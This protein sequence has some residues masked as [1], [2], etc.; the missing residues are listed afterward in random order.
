M[1]RARGTLGVALRPAYAAAATTWAAMLSWRGFT[2]L[3]VRFLTI[4]VVVGLVIS[5]VGAVGRWRGVHGAVVLALQTAA[6]T[7]VASLYIARTPY[8][9]EAFWET[10]RSSVETANLYAAPVPTTATITVQPLL[11]VGG[12]LAMLLVDLLACTWRR[13]P[14]AGLPLLTVYSVPISML[15][16]DL[17]WWVFAAT[18]LGFLTML[19]LQEQEHVGRW[20]RSLDPS[21]APSRRSEAVR[22]SAL[23]VGVVA[24][25]AAVVAP[26]VVPTIDLAVF[27]FGAGRGGS[28]EIKIENPMVDLRRDLRRG[29]DDDLITIT[30]D[31]PSPDHLRI[32][33]LNRFSDEQFSSGDRDVPSANLARGALPPLQGVSASVYAR[34]TTYTYDVSI[35]KNFQSLWL[36]TQ[37]PISEIDA[38]GDWRFDDSTMDFLASD[39]GLTTAGL[40]YTMT[41]VDYDF[42]A[43]ALSS[44]AGPA[45]GISPE[46]TELPAGLSPLIEATARQVT[47]GELT[48]YEKAVAL[49]QWFRED[50]GFIYD[51]EDAPRGQ[52]GADQLVT[53]IDAKRGRVGYCEQFA[54][55]MAVMARTLDIPSRVAV[56][57]LTP[58]RVKGKTWVYSAHDLHAWPELY[59]PGAGWVLFDPTPGD[60]VPDSELPAYTTRSAENE[61]PTVSPSQQQREPSARP[62][63]AERQ[64]PNVTPEKAD[65]DT[66]AGASTFP[67]GRLLLVL[68]IV[69]LL[70]LL[71]LAPRSL[72]ARQRARRLDGGPEGAWD[73][74]RATVVDLGQLWPHTRTPRETE[75]VLVRRFGEVGD[76]AERPAHGPDRNQEAVEALRRIV[77]QVE[78][79]RYAPPGGATSS[80]DLPD[81]LHDDVLTCIAALAAGSSPRGRRV[82][83]WLPRSVVQRQRVYLQEAPPRSEPALAGGVVE[84]I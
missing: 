3:S 21:S 72:R 16:S 76:D 82:A 54:A 37:A 1:S 45:K 69:A 77:R 68:G 17:S 42:L 23:F 70:A 49:Q 12:L 2:D 6:A 14:L 57:F 4:L 33:V 13:V 25:G 27:D 71:L 60:R 56:G 63:Q 50:G 46:V 32:S 26:L 79:L 39:D 61:L 75:A 66:G 40:D 51:I 28:S 9:G 58:D 83:T 24:V 10:L 7:V 38:P 35:R 41:A 36:P 19:F 29:P 80:G 81:R 22:G 78:R 59:F 52:V 73:E 48:K 30:T 62:T 34:R 65:E 31:D 53:F 84:H 64:G 43:G 55:A 11:V 15:E 47:A 8:P 74:L 20:G 67:W 5:T 18:A 44:A